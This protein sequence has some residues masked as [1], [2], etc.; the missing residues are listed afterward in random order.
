MP[1]RYADHEDPAQ[2]R[3]VGGDIH[4]RARR[5]DDD[6]H[7]TWRERYVATEDD[8]DTRMDTPLSK[9]WRCAASPGPCANR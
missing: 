8:D 1:Q 5:H 6:F 7:K 9:N 4:Y 3:H 2:A